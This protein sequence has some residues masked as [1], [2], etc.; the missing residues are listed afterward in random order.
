MQNNPE[1]PSPAQ[2]VY[3]YPTGSTANIINSNHFFLCR[4]L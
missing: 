2:T 1:N 3:I 4:R